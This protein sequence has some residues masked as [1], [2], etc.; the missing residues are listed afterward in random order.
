MVLDPMTSLSRLAAQVRPQRAHV[1]PPPRFHMLTYHGVLAPAATRREEIVPGSGAETDGEVGR[2]R[3][4]SSKR[5]ASEGK[6]R[7]RPERMPWADLL[8]RVWLVD[9]LR[10]EC[11]GRRTVLAMVFNPKSIERV[12]D[13]LGVGLLVA[14][15]R[16]ASSTG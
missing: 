12:L 2:C 14:Q 7:S 5:G 9:I 13:A 11:G 1:V 16:A 3:S 4:K 15:A 10:C 8:R 6:Q